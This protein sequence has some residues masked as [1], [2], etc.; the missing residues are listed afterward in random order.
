M[1][2]SGFVF[3][4]D[5]HVGIVY[6]LDRELREWLLPIIQELVEK[7]LGRPVEYYD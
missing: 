1:L 5:R 2:D 6:L 3:V 4:A 7:Q